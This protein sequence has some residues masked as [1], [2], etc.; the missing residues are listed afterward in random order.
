MKPSHTKPGGGFALSDT[1]VYRHISFD[2]QAFDRLKAWQRYFATQG[3]G[4]TN[5][6]VLSRLILA[7]PVG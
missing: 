3:E 1:Y 2:L 5:S 4:L 6:Q 7:P